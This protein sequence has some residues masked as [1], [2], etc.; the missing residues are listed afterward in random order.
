MNVRATLAVAQFGRGKPGHYTF[1]SVASL[2]FGV[3]RSALLQKA[4]K[5][6]TFT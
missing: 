6:A 1:A 4:K 3:F 2:D 5:Q